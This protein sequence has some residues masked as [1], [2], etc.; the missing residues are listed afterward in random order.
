[1]CPDESEIIH[2]MERAKSGDGPAVREFLSRFEDDVRRMVRG[3]LPRRMRPQFDSMDFV[4]AVWQSF[5][6]GLR[7]LPRDFENVRHLRSYLAGVARNK[8]NEEYRKTRSSRRDIAREEPLYVRHGEAVVERPL[9]SPEPS[10]SQSLQASDRLAQMIAGCGPIEIQVITLR[11]QGLTH[12]EIA[13]RTKLSD[14]S[15]RRI[16]EQARTRMEARE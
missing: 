2:L 12:E 5:F 9:V 15:V 11:C 10:P 13:A 7:K 3:R 4:Q 1:M 8:V 6:S 14:R 16:I